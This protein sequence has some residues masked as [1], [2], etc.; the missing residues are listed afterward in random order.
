ELTKEILTSQKVERFVELIGVVMGDQEVADPLDFMFVIAE[1]ADTEEIEKLERKDIWMSSI[2]AI[3]QIWWVIRRLLE[4]IPKEGIY[5]YLSNLISNPK[6][7]TMAT[8]CLEFCLRQQ[9]RLTKQKK[10]PE[11]SW[12][13]SAEE[14][15]L[16]TSQWLDS[17]SSAFKTR[18][19]FKLS[20][21]RGIIFLLP[22]LNKKLATDL[23]LPLLEND[24][25][26]DSIAYSFGI[27]GSDS[28]KGRFSN[29]S[30]E[31]LDSI[32]GASNIGSRI[33][34]RMKSQTPISIELK[35]I[36][37][38][39]LTGKKFY[40]VDNTEGEPF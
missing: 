25:D 1:L 9:G 5:S 11:E 28:T 37:N 35:A 36:Y 31:F 18:S 13:C 32:G 6:Y 33:L 2:G 20:G 24:N 3:R 19:F 4:K 39:I 21:K 12:L 17:V 15:N 26:I 38:S 40:L 14:L 23:I 16:L 30:Q 8:E 27:S 7:L 22:K 29:V 10:E 34:E